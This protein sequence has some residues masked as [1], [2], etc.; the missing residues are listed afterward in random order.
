MMKLALMN[1]IQALRG[2]CSGRAAFG[3]PKIVTINILYGGCTG[4]CIMCRQFSPLRTSQEHKQQDFPFDSLK[5]LL[6]ELDT[7]GVELVNLCADGEPF[8]YREIMPLLARLRAGRARYQ[9]IT[10]GTVITD[11]HIRLMDNKAALCV[12]VHSDRAEVWSEITGLPQERFHALLAMV[13]RAREAGIRVV[14]HTVVTNRNAD[15]LTGLLKC[16][17][18]FGVPEV[19]ISPFTV[20]HESL[21][22]LKLSREAFERLTRSLPAL[23][24]EARRLNITTNFDSFAALSYS[25]TGSFCVPVVGDGRCSVGWLLSWVNSAGN[26]RFCWNDTRIM[27]NTNTASFRDIWYGPEYTAARERAAAAETDA[28]MCRE[29]PV[30]TVNAAVERVLRFLGMGKNKI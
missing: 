28:A 26:V 12:S 7:M 9:F 23:N 15:E 6:D 18:S 13:R 16:A 14:F 3:P 27:G 11:E 8:L 4:R 1:K 22:S 19:S 20:Y 10:N 29:C 25:D 24:R 5:A 21:S 17:A 2:I 30:Y